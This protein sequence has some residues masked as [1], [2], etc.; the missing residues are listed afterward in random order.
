MVSSC[1][2][3][4][5]GLKLIIEEATSASVTTATDDVSA[6]HLASE[7][8]PTVIVVGRPDTKAS[9]LDSLFQHQGY[10]TKVVIIG[11]D[12]NRIAIY[13]RSEVET[14]TLKDLIKSIEGNRLSGS[15]QD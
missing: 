10:P 9:G 3:L 8:T 4:R 1:P 2:L 11:R 12:D 14:A 13:S 6:I 7:I 15:S 5:E